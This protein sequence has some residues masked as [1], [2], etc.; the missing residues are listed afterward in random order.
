MTI[1]TNASLILHSF[2]GGIGFLI[3]SI[4]AKSLVAEEK[5]KSNEAPKK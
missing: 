1:V 5:E 2:P 3:A 4:P